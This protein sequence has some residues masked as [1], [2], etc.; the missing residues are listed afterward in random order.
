VDRVFLDANVL[1]SAA[2]RQTHTGLRCLWSLRDVTLL[3]SAYA[4]EEA[5]RNLHAPQQRRALNELVL[6]LEVVDVKT[7]TA[8]TFPPHIKLPVKDRPILRAAITGGATHLLTG[9]RKHFGCYFNQTIEGV[10]I[11]LPASYLN[12]RS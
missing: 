11:L 3:S 5:S 7:S 4:I 10:L 2:W 1:Y 8:R 6:A 12:S 9:D